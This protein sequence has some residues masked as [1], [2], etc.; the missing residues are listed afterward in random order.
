MIKTNESIFNE[1]SNEKQSQAS[2][3]EKSDFYE[4]TSMVA[5]MTY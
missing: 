2:F 5:L 1:A 4:I 3:E